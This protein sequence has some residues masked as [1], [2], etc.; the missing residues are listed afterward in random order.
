MRGKIEDMGIYKK[1]K[2]ILISEKTNNISIKTEKFSHEIIKNNKNNYRGLYTY[3]IE[4]EIF[5]GMRQSIYTNTYYSFP[6]YY[7]DT[8]CIIT[9]FFLFLE[10]TNDLKIISINFTEKTFINNFEGKIELI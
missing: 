10:K 4:G 7:F 8:D 6:R 1:I 9:E 2:E 5:D 3:M